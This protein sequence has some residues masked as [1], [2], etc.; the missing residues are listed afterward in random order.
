MKEGGLLVYSHICFVRIIP[1][2][3]TRK[4]L[5]NQILPNKGKDN[6]QKIFA[7]FFLAGQ[8][9]GGAYLESGGRHLNHFE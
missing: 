6:A 7:S 5:K 2:H 9:V 4:Q 1:A 3:F 8:K